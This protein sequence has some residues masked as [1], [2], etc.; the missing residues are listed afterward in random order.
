MT[1]TPDFVSRLRAVVCSLMLGL[2]AACSSQPNAPQPAPL[3][4]DPALLGAHQ[5][6]ST[7]IGAINFPMTLAV[8]ASTVFV[9]DA[10][11][12]LSARD[13]STGTALWQ[14]AVGAPIS[15]GVGSDGRLTSVVTRG[16]DLVTFDG[17]RELWRARLSAQV[18]T[19]P[20]VAGARVFVLAGDRSVTAFDGQTGRKLWSDQHPGDALVLRQAGVLVA[21]D[22]TLVV[23]LA[24]RLVGLEPG[25]GQ[26]LW[27]VAIASPRGTNDVERMVDL[28]SGLGRRGSVICARSFQAAVGCVDAAQGRMLWR[29]V[30]T[31]SVGLHGD[32]EK[33]FGVESDGKVLAWKMTDGQ[34]AWS[35]DALRYR[36]LSAPLVLGRSLVLGDESGQLHFL[37]RADGTLLKRLLTDGSPLAAT[38]VVAGNTLVVVTRK[39]GVF[40]FRPD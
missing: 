23:G 33:V 36:Q 1:N 6:W 14:T 21:V 29:Q 3:G 15:A 25:S 9:S 10:A 20:L 26:T 8:N 4:P 17:G 18:L 34:L 40:G 7:Q 39:G 13:A 27:S 31:G 38:P 12:N 37:S 22:N 19:A 30:A 5:V 11:G 24:G 28:V 2:L 32:D 16:N 35:S